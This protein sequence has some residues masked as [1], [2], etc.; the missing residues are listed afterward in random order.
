MQLSML[1]GTNILTGN[2]YSTLEACNHIHCTLNNITYCGYI[3]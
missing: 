3:L 2:L 1:K